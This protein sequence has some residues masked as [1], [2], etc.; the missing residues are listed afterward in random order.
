[1]NETVENFLRLYRNYRQLSMFT[2]INFQQ[3]SYFNILTSPVCLRFNIR[4]EE[5][6]EDLTSPVCLRFNIRLEEAI[7]EK[8]FS[9]KNNFS[10]QNLPTTRMDV[11]NQIQFRSSSIIVKK[12][13]LLLNLNVYLNITFTLDNIF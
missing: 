13:R 11:L 12:C 8:T 10:K 1:M 5:A 3:F 4:L 7:E 6:I 9:V 2:L